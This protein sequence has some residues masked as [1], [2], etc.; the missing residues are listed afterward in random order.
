MS[1][2]LRKN[3]RG[4]SLA[5]TALFL[6]SVFMPLSDA[7]AFN[8]DAIEEMKVKLNYKKDAAAAEAPVQA[9]N[10]PAPEAK[11]PAQVQTPAQTPAPTAFSAEPLAPVQTA[12]V[13]M[14]E[15]QQ[16]AALPALPE[17]LNLVGSINFALENNRNIK[18][19]E[20]GIKLAD[21]KIREAK[22]KYEPQ[23]SY[24]GVVT[25]MDRATVL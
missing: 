20:K 19:A 2:Y 17:E 16:A 7:Q 15:N 24:Q 5:V 9:Y 10:A 12:S 8:K 6:I 23:L 3:K 1:T 11:Q 4:L 14:I 25:R 22:S 18:S 13:T 21:I